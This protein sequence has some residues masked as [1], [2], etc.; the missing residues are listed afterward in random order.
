MKQYIFND[1]GLRFHTSYLE[2]MKA[3]ILLLPLPEQAEF[4][5]AITHNN[6]KVHNHLISESD[7]YK[8]VP[9]WN[10][11]TIGNLAYIALFHISHEQR[12]WA[13]RIMRNIYESEG[14]LPIGAL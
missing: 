7:I 9:G 5:D 2:K 4:V 12:V 13:R 6:V 1:N 10:V 3:H 14:K 8:S 11:S